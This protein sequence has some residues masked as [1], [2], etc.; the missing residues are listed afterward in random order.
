MIMWRPFTMVGATQILVLQRSQ[1]VE[2]R[3]HQ[4]LLARKGQ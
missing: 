2:H 1:L 4:E 3:R